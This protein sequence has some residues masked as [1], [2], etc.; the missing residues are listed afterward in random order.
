MDVLNG[1]KVIVDVN[2]H[3]Y[4]E[5]MTEWRFF[6]TSIEHWHWPWHRHL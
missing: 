4:C 3:I 5:K 1:Q 2:V 6:H